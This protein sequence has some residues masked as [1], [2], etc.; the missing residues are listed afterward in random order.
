MVRQEECGAEDHHGLTIS[1]PLLQTF[2]LESATSYVQT[3][4]GSV[5]GEVVLKGT[6]KL[7][8]INTGFRPFKGMSTLPY[9]DKL[10]TEGVSVALLDA[11]SSGQE[12][13]D[14]LSPVE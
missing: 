8:Y 12:W 14:Y 5:I 3:L 10:A 9:L 13:E 1:G 4:Q 2:C 11:V 7:S 6:Y